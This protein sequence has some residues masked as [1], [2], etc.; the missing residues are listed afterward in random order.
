MKGVGSCFCENFRIGFIDDLVLQIRL[1]TMGYNV[2]EGKFQP[3][4]GCVLEQVCKSKSRFIKRQG[5]MG[6]QAYG[7]EGSEALEGRHC[8]TS[9]F[10]KSA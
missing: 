10:R 8:S 4:A 3:V 7:A 2:N 6:K 1:E 9:C 5:W